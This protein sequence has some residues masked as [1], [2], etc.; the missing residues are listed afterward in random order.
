[1][2]LVLVIRVGCLVE[3]EVLE[4]FKEKKIRRR[5]DFGETIENLSKEGR[6]PDPGATV[7]VLSP[8]ES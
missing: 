2:F 8:V 4:R 6:T 7:M 3:P 5:T 1:M